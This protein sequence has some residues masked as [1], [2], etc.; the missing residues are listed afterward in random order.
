MASAGTP[1]PA[2]GPDLHAETVPWKAGERIER[3]HDQ[4][5]GSTQFNPANT[6][7]S[8][9]S[10]IASKGKIIPTLYG[11]TTFDCAAMESVF[12]D[13]PY[14]PG[15][16]AFD[17]D[18][19]QGKRASVISPT[20][21]LQ[22]IN[23]ASKALRKLGITRIQLIESD[24]VDYINTRPWAVALHDQFPQSDG[25]VWVSR[26]DDEAQALVLFGDRVRKPDLAEVASPRGIAGDPVIYP[27]LLD[28]ARRIGVNFI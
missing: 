8:R 5:Y 20:R 24:S 2:P 17:K 19:L 18:K 22:L 6:S 11:G 28:L 21:D 9:F 27:K 26:Q 12:R 14:S 16:K 7:D 25:L 15:F 13:I 23:L 1:F 10:P 4:K 3:I